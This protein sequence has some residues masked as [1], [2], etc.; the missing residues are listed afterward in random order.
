MMSAA[1]AII[2]VVH[3]KIQVNTDPIVVYKTI[4]NV[5]ASKLPN[6]IEWTIKGKPGDIFLIVIKNDGPFEDGGNVIKKGA[7][8]RVGPGVIATKNLKKVVR[9]GYWKYT[10]VRVRGTDVISLDPRISVKG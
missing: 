4:K 5:R 2:S 1:T 3:G 6:K 10:I 8:W 7:Y 9:G